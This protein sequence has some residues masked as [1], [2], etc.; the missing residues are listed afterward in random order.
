MRLYC[1]DIHGY[2]NALYAIDQK[3]AHLG[4]NAIIQCGD[5]GFYWPGSP[6]VEEYFNK[7]AKMTFEIP[8]FVID[9][10]H[11]NHDELDARWESAGRPAVVEIAKNLYHVRRGTVIEI[12]GVK[13]LMCGGARSTDRGPGREFHRGRRIWWKQE[14]PSKE[15][16]DRFFAALT[17]EKPE[18]IV[19]H[20]AP[21][22]VPLYREGRYEDP[23]ARAFEHSLSLTSH[24]PKHW[25]FGHHHM[26]DSW[27]TEGV[28]F[29]CAGYHGQYW[30][31]NGD[32]LDVGTKTYT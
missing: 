29:R 15:E 4:V 14:A 25:F 22:C 7:R 3:A 32:E 13:H 28:N 10:N 21:N 12:D 8:W 9:G 26:L 2:S 1:G 31:V 16:L 17:T 19:T 5:M 23:T 27:D 6:T 20:D 30:L 18:V 11:E 24:R